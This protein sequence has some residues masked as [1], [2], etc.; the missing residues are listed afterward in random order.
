[1]PFLLRTQTS[2]LSRVAVSL[3]Q[4]FLSLFHPPDASLSVDRTLW[5]VSRLL[6]AAI[7]VALAAAVVF[8][9]YMIFRHRK[10]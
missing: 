7:Y 10:K 1:M 9:C 6:S 3:W 4:R 2:E 5:N 8:I